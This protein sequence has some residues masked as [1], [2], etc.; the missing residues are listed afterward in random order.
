MVLG[1]HGTERSG[2][3]HVSSRE[4]RDFGADGAP[5][6]GTKPACSPTMGV[7]RLLVA[8][9]ALVVAIGAC[10]SNPPPS[11]LR[12]L[13]LSAEAER[14]CRSSAAALCARAIACSPPLV[15]FFFGSPGLCE[16]D[17][18]TIC[19]LR[20]EGSGAARAPASCD[21]VAANVPCEAIKDMV[22]AGI[23]RPAQTLMRQCPVTP[24]SFSEGTP[25]L[26]HGDCTSGFCARTTD[27]ECGRCALGPGEGDACI[28]GTRECPP[29]LR[30]RRDRCERIR[31]IGD[32][33]SEGTVCALGHCGAD[34]HCEGPA[35]LDEAC[36]VNTGPWCDLGLALSCAEDGRCRKF[37]VVGPGEPCG[38]DLDRPAGTAFCAG[39]GASRATCE[40]DR[41]VDQVT[42]SAFFWPPLPACTTS[43][44]CE[45]GAGCVNRHCR[46]SCVVH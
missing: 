43:S 42:Q 5:P 11:L 6:P 22:R 29:P 40:N 8:T 3:F 2:G 19:A 12:P 13:P 38:G 33:C 34:G 14:S 41:C 23:E 15:D 36:N 37:T 28:G 18:F 25:C 35:R 7:T 31:K 20:Y 16:K 30:C 46:A 21:A 1:S 27:G 26:D 24:G 9:G 44:E 17:V 39:T 32:Q 4:H 10:T 45:G